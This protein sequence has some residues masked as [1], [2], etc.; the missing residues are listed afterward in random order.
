MS[1][2][3][4]VSRVLGQ[5]RVAVLVWIVGTTSLA[6]NAFQYANAL[7]SQLQTLLISG[8][9]SAVL[10]PQVVRAYKRGAGAE[11]VNRLLTF[12]F[13]V[14]AVVTLVATA[15]VPLLVMVY[16]RGDADPT[17]IALTVAFGYWTMPQ[18]F[19]YGVYALVG[20]VLNARGSFGPY[21]W[22]PAVNNVVAITTMVV[23]VWQFHAWGNQAPRQWTASQVALLAGGATLGIVAQALVLVPALR[24]AGVRY[25]P[26]WG[27]RGAGLAS[28]GKV[29]LWTF[30]A[31]AIAQ[32][33]VVAVS[34]VAA[35]VP[36]VPGTAGKAVYD[37][38]LMIFML[39]HSL[40]TVSLLTALFPR[41]SAQAADRAHTDVARTFSSTVRVVGLFTVL[42]A[43][44]GLLLAGPVARVV[45]PTINPVDVA[46]MSKVVM[47]FMVGLPA[48]GVWSACQRVYYAYE[49][50]RSLV[51]VAVGSAAVV[52]LGTLGVW[53]LLD[54]HLWV[55][56]A[57]L[58][59]S[60]SYLLSMAMAL[61]GLKVRIGA[62][63]GA[64]ILRTYLRATFAVA[65]AASSG[66]AALR[67]LRYLG[68]VD[69]TGLRG[70]LVA[71]GVCVIVGAVCA[72][73][74]L[75][76]LKLL[77]VRE[78]DLLIGSVRK[79]ITRLKRR[80]SD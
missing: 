55:F 58:S 26:Q 13:V 40:V 76:L 20:Q 59:M 66:L 35:A 61:S 48:Y 38:G 67:G 57:A 28:A 56:G 33:T 18:L 3:T 29:A 17:R 70:W 60:A 49:D 1:L 75:V 2:G 14:L 51:P 78:L 25:R 52:L 21:M 15:A 22:A 23:F 77:R 45:I 63:G 30:V 50:A 41:L 9:L 27:F 68:M 19:F 31:L 5:V 32:V 53:R 36:D 79:G 6:A 7:P 39:P 42:V 37:Y 69:S 74:Y 72:G 62:V 43:T 44:L 8:A 46:A 80:R 34:Q 65:V 73:T 71:V 16:A 47:A 10:I 24:R 12:G 4:A 64:A 54:P 11:Y